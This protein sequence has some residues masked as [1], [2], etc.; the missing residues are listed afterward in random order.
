MYRLFFDGM[1]LP[2]TPSSIDYKIKNQNRTLT[3]I[4]GQEINI[5]KTPG[6]Q[7]ISFSL[8]LPRHPYSFCVEGTFK[9]PETFIEKFHEL[10]K[11][12]FTF[13]LLRE[14]DSFLGSFTLQVSMEDFSITE[15]NPDYVVQIR[16]KEFKEYA[17]Q[18][19]DTILPPEL[20]PEG[21]GFSSSQKVVMKQTRAAATA[22]AEPDLYT[23]QKNDTYPNI[24]RKLYGD[25]S[26]WFQL[27]EANEKIYPLRIGDVLRIKK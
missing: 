19:I 23:V 20:A 14:T 15:D 2:V 21:G 3:L 10:K 4:T 17:G 12:N 27:Y 9:T 18:I 24:A 13:V 16:L 1:P 8:L 7:E 25:D 22:P 6:L 26:L 11:K 5:L